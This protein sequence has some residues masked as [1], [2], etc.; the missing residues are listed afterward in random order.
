MPLGTLP[1]ATTK[2]MR[3]VMRNVTLCLMAT[4]IAISV[5][6]SSAQA[7]AFGS[8]E[9]WQQMDSDGRGGRGG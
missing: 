5:L 7:A 4:W 9:W 1:G 3:Q 2:Q 6:T 8:S